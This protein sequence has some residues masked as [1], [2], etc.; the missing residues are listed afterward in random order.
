[1]SEVSKIDKLKEKYIDKDISGFTDNDL[2]RDLHV[3]QNEDLQNKDLQ[4]EDLQEQLVVLIQTETK[5]RGDEQMEK[6]KLLCSNIIKK[7]E[8]DCH[9]NCLSVN[10]QS[11]KLY[12]EYNQAR[13]LYKEG[14]LYHDILVESV[15]KTCCCEDG[16]SEE[17]LSAKPAEKKALLWKKAV[18][19]ATALL[20]MSAFDWYKNRL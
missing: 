7:L 13:D 9:W 16:S 6:N 3:L 15:F 11:A 18:P 1:M 4:N 10:Q 2:A 8:L 14:S 5:R 19:V 20:A 17:K 12:V